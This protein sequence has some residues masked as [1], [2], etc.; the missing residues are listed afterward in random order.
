MY[1]DTTEGMSEE[2]A[3]IAENINEEDKY[4]D[5]RKFTYHNLEDKG[6]VKGLRWDPGENG[7]VVISCFEMKVLFQNGHIEKKN[8]EDVVHNGIRV[9]NELI[10]L[11]ADPQMYFSLENE[12]IISEI[13]I[14]CDFMPN[15]SA[16]HANHFYSAYNNMLAK[17]KKKGLI[18]RIHDKLFK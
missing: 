11:A 10:F 5:E 13:L 8:L 4:V 17:Q 3:V 6:I 7:N 12:A 18:K 16:N 1:F 9:G 14:E 15:I 2:K